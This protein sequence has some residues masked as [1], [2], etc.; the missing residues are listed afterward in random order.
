MEQPLSEEQLTV[1]MKADWLVSMQTD[2]I[3]MLATSGSG[4]R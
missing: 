3:S 4:G 2:L 1:P